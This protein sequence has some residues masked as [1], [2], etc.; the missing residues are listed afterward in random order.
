MKERFDYYNKTTDH[1]TGINRRAGLEYTH[2]I[3]ACN[4]YMK[5]DDGHP[6]NNSRVEGKLPRRSPKKNQDMT[7]TGY[8]TIGGHGPE[9]YQ[10][11]NKNKTRV[12]EL[13]AAK[14]AK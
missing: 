7:F 10:G 14:L 11:G 9:I 4:L 5:G 8:S 12:E 1:E 6:L 2:V 3:R 13:S